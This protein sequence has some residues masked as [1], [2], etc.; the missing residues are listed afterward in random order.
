MIIID[1]SEGE[2]GGQVLRYACALALLTSSRRARGAPFEIQD[3]A[4]IF[5]S[6]HT[7]EPLRPALSSGFRE[8]NRAHSK[9]ATTAVEPRLSVTQRLAPVRSIEGHVALTTRESRR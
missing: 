7:R 9:P 2:G 5:F 4:L 8:N 1:G 6:L 3:E